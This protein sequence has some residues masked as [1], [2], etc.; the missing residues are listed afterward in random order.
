M[1]TFGTLIKLAKK[2]SIDKI[3]QLIDETNFNINEL[4][5]KSGKGLIHFAI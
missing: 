4:D 3:S 5:A 1:N 2:G